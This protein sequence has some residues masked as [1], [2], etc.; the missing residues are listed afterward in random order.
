VCSESLLAA[1]SRAALCVV[2]L[3]ASLPVAAQVETPVNPDSLGESTLQLPL[4]ITGF[5]EGKFAYDFASG[6]NSFDASSLNFSFFKAF[7]DRLSFFGQVAVAVN[8]ETA[9]VNGT[10]QTQGGGASVEADIDNLQITWAASPSHGLQIVFGKFD[11][12]MTL[13]RDDAPLNLEATRSYVFDFGEPVKFAG[14]M[15]RQVFSQEFEGMVIVSNG[16]DVF[17]DNNKAKTGAVWGVWS[18]SPNVHF[19][20]GGIFGAE[21]DNNNHDQRET[22]IATIQVQAS[23]SWLWGG[24]AVYGNEA[25]SAVAGGAAKWIGG[26]IVSFHKFGGRWASAVRFDYFDDVG[27]ARTGVRQVLKDV[28]VSPQYLIGSGFFGPYHTLDYSTVRIPEMSVRLDLR[29]DWSTEPVFANSQ[30]V[31]QKSKFTTTLQ[32]VYVF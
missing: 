27:G 8:E 2:I 21:K 1:R 31:G 5:A 18:P 10:T 16:W 13:E 30:G 23:D 26:E 25:N 24:E 29:Y 12:P 9:F 3:F 19:G 22:G 28:T 4:Q 15:A 32:V 14:I 7:S 6:Q 11:S 17:P 20:F